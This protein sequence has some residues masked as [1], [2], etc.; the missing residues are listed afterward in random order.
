[1]GGVT[2]DEGCLE[3]RLSRFALCV[4]PSFDDA[5]DAVDAVAHQSG[6]PSAAGTRRAF[7]VLI[8]LLT[9]PEEGQRRYEGSD[10]PSGSV[11]A[12]FDCLPCR[13]RAA[14]TLVLIEEF[15]MEEAAAI[16][17]VSRDELRQLLAGCRDFLFA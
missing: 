17:D 15:S 9:A 8:R 4:A 16:M 13:Q 10:P 5:Y 2:G 1:M 11:A 7:R 14:L 6:D 12:R 3:A